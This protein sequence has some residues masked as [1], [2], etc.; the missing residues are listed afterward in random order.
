MSIPPRLATK[1]NEVFGPPAAEDLVSWMDDTRAD[2][3][4]LRADIAELRQ[5]MRA[6]EMRIIA[7]M[8]KQF[9]DNT[10][11]ITAQIA[12]LATDLRKEIHVVDNKIERRF[13][14]LLLWS[15]VFWVGAVAAIAMLAR[16][17]GR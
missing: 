1:L 14:D 7:R 16:I 10:A 8:D 17:L 9:A 5:E 4:E 6:T 2:H 13:S 11:A 3:A 15:F 12:S